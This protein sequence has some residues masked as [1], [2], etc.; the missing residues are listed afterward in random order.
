MTTSGVSTYDSARD[1]IAKKAL[2]LVGAYPAVSE[3]TA[4]QLRDCVEAMNMMLKTWQTHNN[5]WLRQYVKLFLVPEQ[6]E[7]SLP[8]AKG[9]SEVVSTTVTAAAAAGAGALVVGSTTGMAAGNLIGVYQDDGT[10]HWTTIASVDSSTGLTLT[11]VLTAAVSASAG[12]YAYASGNALYRPTRVFSAR[13]VTAGGWEAPMTPISREDYTQLP[14]KQS[15][16]TPVQ[17]YF[18]AQL[19]PA[20]FYVWPTPTTASEYLVLDVDRPIQVML[21]SDDTSD[22]PMEWQEAIAYGTAARIAPEYKLPLGDRQLLNQE[23]SALL[24]AVMSANIEHV[25]V[26]FQPGE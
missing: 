24:A 16:G 1:V 7:Y 12:V 19:S 11:A 3:P 25:P 13:R 14:G 21:D 15:I 5:I 18:N 2:R 4:K 20:K 6:G 23:Y 9:A 10:L 8:G 17:Y 26:Y 22:L